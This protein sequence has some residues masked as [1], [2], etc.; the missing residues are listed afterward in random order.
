MHAVQVQPKKNPLLTIGEAWEEKSNWFFD[1]LCD[2]QHSVHNST[3]LWCIVL[4]PEHCTDLFFFIIG[5]QKYSSICLQVCWWFLKSSIKIK[6][7]IYITFLK[8]E[9]CHLGQKKIQNNNNSLILITK[10]PSSSSLE[11]IRW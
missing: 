7:Y 11:L 9:P 1:V 2:I 3:S 6:K 4:H 5:K 10:K 8:S